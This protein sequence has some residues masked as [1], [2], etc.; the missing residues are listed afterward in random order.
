[1]KT[2]GLIGGMSWE[3]TLDYY[4]IINRE[5]ARR[6]GGLNSAKIL[7]SS[8]NFTEIA[9]IL[10]NRNWDEAANILRNEAVRLE[11]AGADMILICTN[12]MHMVAGEVSK[13][14]DIPLLHIAEATADKIAEAGLDKVGLLGTLPT[15]EL[16]FYRDKLAQK[17]I[18]TV[19]P[20]LKD[21][22]IAHCV[23]MDELCLGRFR[24][25]SRREYL[26]IISEMAKQGAQGVVLGCTEI[27]LLLKDSN[28]ALP[29]FDTTEIHSLAAVDMALG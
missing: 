24:D 17:G 1:M 15:M 12:T 9:P 13:S 3:S 6:L 22:E 29:L 28:P 25:E 8:V 10:K 5:T 7:L 26:R 19:I 27:P 16:N 11:N 20:G 4:R 21:M 2:I 14:V 18:E 23:I